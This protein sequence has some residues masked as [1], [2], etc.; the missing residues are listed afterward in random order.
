MSADSLTG[1]AIL[2]VAFFVWDY[3]KTKL[4]VTGKSIFEARQ[5]PNQ[6]FIDDELDAEEAKMAGITITGMGAGTGTGD[7]SVR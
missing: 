6:E 1:M 2:M 7:S 3:S 5:H 4:M